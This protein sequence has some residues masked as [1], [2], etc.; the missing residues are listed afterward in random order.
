MPRPVK[1]RGF[2]IMIT[3]RKG[4]TQTVYFTGAEKATLTDPYYLFTFTHRTTGEIVNVP[5]TNASTTDRYQK[6]SLVTN[7]YLG[8]STDGLYSYSIREYNANR[9][10]DYQNEEFVTLG[11]VVET[12]Y[13]DL[14]PATDFTPTEYE[15]QS[16]TFKTYNG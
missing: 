14:L 11:E 10:Q 4:A 8:S 1:R 2:L 5:C 6:F 3:L 13:M 15:S 7:N 12:G 16:N 9:P